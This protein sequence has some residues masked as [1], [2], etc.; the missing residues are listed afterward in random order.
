MRWEMKLLKGRLRFPPQNKGMG[1]WERPMEAQ[2]APGVADSWSGR[3]GMREESWMRPGGKRRIPQSQAP[4]SRNLN[5]GSAHRSRNTETA[6]WRRNSSRLHL[7][8]G[9]FLYHLF[10]APSTRACG[11]PRPCAREFPV[12]K[13][14][15]G[16]AT[17]SNQAPFLF[18]P[19]GFNSTHLQSRC[20]RRF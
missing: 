6:G 16:D 14:R 18:I 12:P 15:S 19:P 11:G 8:A 10:Q 1:L 17:Q 5:S 13:A 20:F 2:N 9:T 4:G 7:K 3:S